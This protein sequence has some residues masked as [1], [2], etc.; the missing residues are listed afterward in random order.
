MG[1]CSICKCRSQL[2][3]MCQGFSRLIYLKSFFFQFLKKY[4]FFLCFITWEEASISL[5][6]WWQTNQLSTN[7]QTD[8]SSTNINIC[9]RKDILVNFVGTPFCYLLFELFLIFKKSHFFMFIS[10]FH[11]LPLFSHLVPS[12]VFPSSLPQILVLVVYR[13]LGCFN[14]W[15][16]VNKHTSLKTQT[17]HHSQIYT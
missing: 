3:G 17:C 16:L 11:C 1:S 8:Q 7:C 9:L 10:S 12:P 2:W 5:T 4:N 6:S 15:L 14:V 13:L